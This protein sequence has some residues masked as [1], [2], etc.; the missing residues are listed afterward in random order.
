MISKGFSK[1]IKETDRRFYMDIPKF[2]NLIDD[3]F[4]FTNQELS[5]TFNFM[6]YDKQ[7][8]TIF[9]L[10]SLKKLFSLLLTF[11]AIKPKTIELVKKFVDFSAI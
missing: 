5:K 11:K 7:K 6:R 4:Y 1:Y 2:E 10:E 3:K 9:G 8:D